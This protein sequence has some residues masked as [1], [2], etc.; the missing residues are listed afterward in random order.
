MQTGAVHWTERLS[1]ECWASPIVADGNIVFFT[2]GGDVVAY[3]VS[4]TPER[5]AESSISTTDILYGVAAVEGAWV[6]RTGR[7]LIKIAAPP[8]TNEPPQSAARG[9]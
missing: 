8:T 2:K 9:D 7:G 1:G 5:I 4:R 6:A 3:K